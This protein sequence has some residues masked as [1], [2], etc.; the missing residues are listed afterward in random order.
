MHDMC[1]FVCV[2]TTCVYAYT[3]IRVCV[4]SNAYLHLRA[5]TD[6]YIMC[7]S[8]PMFT[9]IHMS[10][11]V[12]LHLDIHTYT[13]THIYIYT[14]IQIIIYI[15]ACVCIR[16]CSLHM[17]ILGYK[18]AVRNSG[19]ARHRQH[20]RGADVVCSARAAALRPLGAGGSKGL[21]GFY[22]GVI[23]GY[24]GILGLGIPCTEEFKCLIDF[25][26]LGVCLFGRRCCPWGHYLLQPRL[27]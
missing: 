6:A 27:L 16:V 15:Y 7:I 3:H 25:W 8:I 2:C 5:S 18:I 24:S 11:P 1:T 17:C 22:R 12:S 19:A 23:L 14:Y 13:H 9:S 10:L 20:R 4:Y 21:P 26:C